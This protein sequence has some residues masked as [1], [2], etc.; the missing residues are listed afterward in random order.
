[1]GGHW[2][3]GR[4]SYSRASLWVPADPEFMGRG[5]KSSKGGSLSKFHHIFLKFPHET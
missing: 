4:G 3:S 5:F 1:M 2:S